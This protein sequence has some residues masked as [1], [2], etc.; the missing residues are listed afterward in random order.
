ML[1]GRE[2]KKD[3]ENPNLK[4]KKKKTYAGDVSGDPVA[5][6]PCSNAGGLGSIL[7]WGT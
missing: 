7:G 5:K 1:K 4:K 2:R 3:T 6:T